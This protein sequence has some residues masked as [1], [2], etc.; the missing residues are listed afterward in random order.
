MPWNGLPLH[1][2]N[3]DQA[4]DREVQKRSSYLESTTRPCHKLLLRERIACK[5]FLTKR[6]RQRVQTA[7]LLGRTHI[8]KHP[9]RRALAFQQ[10][11]ETIPKAAVTN[12]P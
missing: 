1:G 9:I 8:F 6:G 7:K 3:R 2:R 12:L 5:E 11:K 10:M 4:P